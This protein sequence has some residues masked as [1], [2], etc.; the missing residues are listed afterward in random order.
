MVLAEEEAE[1]EFV[2]RYLIGFA[3]LCFTLAGLASMSS[4]GLSELPDRGARVMGAEGNEFKCK[5]FF[6]TNTCASEAPECSPVASVCDSCDA[7]TAMLGRCRDTIKG[8]CNT[9]DPVTVNCGAHAVGSCTANWPVP[10]QTRCQPAF[11]TTGACS[12]TTLDKCDL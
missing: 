10:G 4:R 8:R 3:V 12:T 5:L 11:T 9:H 2:N 6:V 7:S 1:E